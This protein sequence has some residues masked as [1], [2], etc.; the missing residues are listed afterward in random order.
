M[1]GHSRLNG[2]AS[3]IHAPAIHVFGNKH[4]LSENWRAARQAVY[5]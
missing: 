5:S 1:A 4:V 2:V 3:L